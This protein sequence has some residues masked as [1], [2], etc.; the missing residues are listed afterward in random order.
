MA[1]K[2]T[3]PKIKN[4]PALN[5]KA[6]AL[7]YKPSSLE[8]A[9]LVS[10]KGKGSI[11]NAIIEQAEKYNVPVVQNAELTNMLS[12]VDVGEEIPTEAFLAVAEIMRYVYALKGEVPDFVPR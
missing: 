1:N 4:N 5:K 8:D 6:V 9:P 2:I 12:F 10:A 7:T 3:N 11:A